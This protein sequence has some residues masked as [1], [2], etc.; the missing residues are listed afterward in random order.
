[1]ICSLVGIFGHLG[2]VEMASVVALSSSVQPKV[3]VF[4]IIFK[5][6]LL[7]EKKITTL[8]FAME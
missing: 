4:H 7:F 6:P 1:M 3:C 2:R 5:F 8:K